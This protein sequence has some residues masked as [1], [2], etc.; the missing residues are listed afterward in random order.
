M[1]D[2][3]VHLEPVEGNYIGGVPAVP[4]DVTEAEA[5]EL[6]A[7]SPPAFVVA[8]P[9]KPAKEPAHPASAPADSTETEE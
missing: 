4:M 2:K 3:L 9:V 7:W 1:A 5:A 6:L 8:P